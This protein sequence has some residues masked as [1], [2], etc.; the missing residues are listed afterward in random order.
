MICSTTRPN[1]FPLFKDHAMSF[2]SK[3][4]EHFFGLG[5]SILYPFK[6]RFIAGKQG[7]PPVEI[8]HFLEPGGIESAVGE[9]AFDRRAKFGFLLL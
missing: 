9:R 2:L 8:L 5:A 4:G 6:F 7:R 3:A 1:A